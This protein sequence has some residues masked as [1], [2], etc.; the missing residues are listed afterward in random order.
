MLNWPIGRPKACCRLQYSRV[1]LNTAC[2]PARAVDPIGTRSRGRF[3]ISATKPPPSAPSRFAAGTLT[4]LKNSSEVSWAPIPD[5]V[6]RSRSVVLRGVDVVD[7]AVHRGTH[8][9][10]GFVG[11]SRWPEDSVA[12]ELHRAVPGPV[13][14]PD[15]VRRTL[16][17]RG[18]VRGP[19]CRLLRRPNGVPAWAA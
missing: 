18:P 1:C 6:Q 9:A 14:A 13:Y 12:G 4:S 3:S 10:H 11:I 17:G 2:A 8:H 5:F 15:P 7:S 16:R 19:T